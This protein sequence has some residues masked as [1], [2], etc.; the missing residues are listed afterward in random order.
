[1][2]EICNK[3]GSDILGENWKYCP[4]TSRNLEHFLFLALFFHLSPPKIGFFHRNEN[5]FLRLSMNRAII[6]LR[7]N[8]LTLHL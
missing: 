3:T 4:Q 5:Y 8:V 1:M 6:P 7:F 2:P